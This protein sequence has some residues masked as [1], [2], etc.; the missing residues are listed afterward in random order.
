MNR[1]PNAW[2]VG[3]FAEM[4]DGPGSHPRRVRV[5]AFVGNLVRVELP[6]GSTRLRGHDGILRISDRI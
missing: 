1:S 3:D 6:D 5:V 2:S 4:I